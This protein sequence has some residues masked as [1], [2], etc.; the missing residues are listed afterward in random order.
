[1]GHLSIDVTDFGLALHGVLDAG[2]VAQLEHL[3]T[4][5]TSRGVLLLDLADLS[6]IDDVG[7]KGLF[8]LRRR[9]S[10]RDTQVVLFDV[11]PGIWSRLTESGLDKVFRVMR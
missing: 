7:L 3:P 1:M 4:E 8:A 9:L 2:S 11:P 6:S 10:T 5:A